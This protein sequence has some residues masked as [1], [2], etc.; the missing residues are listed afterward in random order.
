MFLRSITKFI[1]I[2]FLL[3]NMS[4][5]YSQ[6][7]TEEDLDDNFFKVKTKYK[8]EY[9][10]YFKFN[11]FYRGVL[12]KKLKADLEVLDNK[13]RSDW[14]YADSVQ[15]AKINLTV[16]NY[17][18]AA[19]YFEYLEINPRY[20]KETNL[21]YIISFYVQGRYKEGLAKINKDYHGTV[22][23]SEL[24][25]IKKI[26]ESRDSL[27]LNNKWYR[28]KTVFPFDNDLS[29]FDL[30][31][32]SEEFKNKIITPL[33]NSRT[34]LEIFVKYIHKN[35][36]I[37]ARAFNDIG[38]CLERH[39]SIQEAYIAYNIAR[40]YNK[41]DK[42]IHENIDRVKLKME[43]KNYKTPHFQRVFPSIDFKRLNYDV[44]KEEISEKNK[45]EDSQKLKQPKLVSEIEKEPIIDL[46]FP[47]E[48]IYT[49]GLLL[50]FLFVLIFVKTKKK[51]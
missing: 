19:Y 29:I 44:L 32:K 20:E 39:I 46:P 4:E 36:P 8:N 10:P 15:F 28:N 1:S 5:S 50:L 2:L 9:N 37:I 11:T 31:K 3:L 16:G 22:E 21:L 47:I 23:Y 25:Y 45:L 7:N 18:L 6:T 43:A 41:R 51:K 27:E 17:D 40:K 24:Y 26:F 35:D 14:N 13:N 38:L 33:E 34:V 12:D 30:D 48:T 42:E 49:I